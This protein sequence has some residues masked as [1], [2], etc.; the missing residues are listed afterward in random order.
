MAPNLIEHAPDLE[1]F[2]ALLETLPWFQCLGQ[3]HERDPEVVRLRSWDA[4]PGPQGPYGDWFGRW[5]SVVREQ[6]EASYPD[7][8]ETLE[9][10][11][12]R[13]ERLVLD[14][15]PSQVQLFDPNEDAWFGPTSCIWG[16]AYTACLVGWHLALQRDWPPRL[17]SEW[18]WYQAGHWPCGYAAEPP[19][20]CD[21]ASVDYPVGRLLVY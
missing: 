16:A 5:Q 14:R 6:L 4:W 21:E 3:P 15:A 2:L 8:L 13:I 11:W 20:Y 9:P 12:Q 7:R 1:S 17:T 10:L 18:A 19:G